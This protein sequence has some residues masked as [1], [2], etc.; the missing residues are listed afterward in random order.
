MRRFALVLLVALSTPLLMGA[1]DSVFPALRTRQMNQADRDTLDAISAYL[2]GIVTLKGGF[3]Q[4]APTGDTSE[5][6]FYLSK[7]GKLRFEYNP[8]APTL[9]V[10]DGH[11]VAVVNRRLRTVDT[12]PLF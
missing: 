1:N 9:L 2:N 5:G 10:A 8:P 12:Y 11:D 3:V 7:P 6:T 4:I